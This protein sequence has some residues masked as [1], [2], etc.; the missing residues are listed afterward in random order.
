MA[1]TMLSSNGQSTKKWQQYI[2]AL[3]AAGGAV[4][5][6]TALVNKI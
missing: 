3:S 5:M 1:D 2:A 6:G 4:A